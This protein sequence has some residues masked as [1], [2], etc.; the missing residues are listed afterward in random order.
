MLNDAQ[1]RTVSVTIRFLEEDL[2]EMEHLLQSGDYIGI[3][4]EMGND[5]PLPTKKALL[6][7][8]GAIKDRIHSLV[9]RFSLKKE[10]RSVRRQLFARSTYDLTM[11]EETK[12]QYL[13]GYGNTAKGLQDS[14]DPQLDSMIDLL[15]EMLRLLQRDDL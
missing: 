2:H 7:K 12:T 13:K 8:I 11:L 4:H 6:D 14:L 5:I 10:Q 9:E 1:R 15:R 3:V